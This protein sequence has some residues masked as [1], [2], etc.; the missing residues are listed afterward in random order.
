MGSASAAKKR[1]PRKAKGRASPERPGRMVFT[2]GTFDDDDGGRRLAAPATAAGADAGAAPSK[3][4]L[5]R[6][7]LFTMGSNSEVSDMDGASSDGAGLEKRATT[8]TAHSPSQLHVCK[9]TTSLSQ[10]CESRHSPGHSREP[11]EPAAAAQADAAAGAPQAA[12]R[13]GPPREGQ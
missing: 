12:A 9:A 1:A 7:P 10:L 11:S 3:T 5:R 4:L 13:A 8:T 6:Q 2:V